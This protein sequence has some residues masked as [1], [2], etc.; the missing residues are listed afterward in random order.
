MQSSRPPVAADANC[1]RPPDPPRL[2]A[3]SP[4][5]PTAATTSPTTLDDGSI[6]TSPGSNQYAHL[7]TCDRTRSATS[8][9]RESQPRTVER[10]SPNLAA[11]GRHPHPCARSS[12]A[13]PIVAAHSPRRS[14]IVAGSSTCVA[15]HH[16]HRDRRGTTRRPDP[17]RPT[18]RSRAHPH[19]PSTPTSHDGHDSNPPTSS[20]STRTGSGLT[21]IMAALLSQQEALPVVLQDFAGRASLIPDPA[22]LPHHPVRQPPHP[23]HAHPP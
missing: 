8:T 2:L 3:A 11:I 9:S 13:R 21:V 14:S 16:R 5:A 4:T 18:S 6:R 12:T 1:H 7:V 20:D 23:T 19:G 22:T 10:A 15:R 17:P